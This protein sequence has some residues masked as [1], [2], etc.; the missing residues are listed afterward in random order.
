MNK[1][2]MKN[3]KEKSQFDNILEFCNDCRIEQ[4]KQGQISVILFSL[5]KFS[6]FKF[7]KL[8]IRRCHSDQF[9]AINILNKTCN[10]GNHFMELQRILAES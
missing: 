3:Q 2:Y 8:F 4:S 7:I 5:M 6:A 1:N 9:D 10:Y